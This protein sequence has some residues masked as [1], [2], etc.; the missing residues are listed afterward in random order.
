[1]ELEKSLDRRETGDVELAQ[2]VSETLFGLLQV[3]GR[4]TEVITGVAQ[5]RQGRSE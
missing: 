3:T 5:R 2:T 1:M 4:G